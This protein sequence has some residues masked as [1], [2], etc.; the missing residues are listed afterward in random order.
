MALLSTLR[1]RC[2]AV[3]AALAPASVAAA[4][5]V[6]YEQ[7]QQLTTT[8][9]TP[10]DRLPPPG[11]LHP[12]LSAT[13]PWRPLRLP[14]VVPRAAVTPIGANSGVEVAWYRLRHPVSSSPQPLAL[15]TA[16]VLGGPIEV[17]VQGRSLYA[18]RQEWY[19]QWN[20]PVLVPIPVDVQ[21]GATDL[22]IVIGLARR[23]GQSHAMSSLWVGPEAEVR[24]LY[25]RRWWLQITAPQVSSLTILVLGA[26]S[27]AFWLR[28]RHETA[29]LL[30]AL[31]SATWFVRNL[32]YHIDLPLAPFAYAWFWWLSHA[33]LSWV[34]V[35]VYLF[36]FRFHSERYPRVER[37]LVGFTLLISI[38]TL[39]LWPWA[40]DL[41]V[42]QHMLNAAVS[43]GVTA[44]VSVV[45]VR[46]GGPELRVMM[47][48]LWVG[49]AL[50][51]HDLALVAQQITPESI[52]LMPY[53]SLVLFGAFLY[54]VQRRYVGAITQVEQAN[55]EMAHQ[56]L[57][58]QRELE[59]NYQRLALAEKEQARLTERQRLMREMHD[60][61]GST[62]TSSLVLLEQGQLASH[63]VADVLR[64]CVDDLRLTLDSLEP[65]DHDLLALLALLRRRLGRRLEQTG[66]AFDWQVRDLPPLPWLDATAGLHLLRI[67]QESLVNAL[68]HARAETVRVETALVETDA[69]AARV[70]VRITDDGFGFD[71]TA[72]QQA[73]LGGHGWKNMHW[74]AA[75]LG[76][77]IEIESRRGRTAVSLW[78]PVAVPEA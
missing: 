5:P 46:R 54:A 12:D 63:A 31:A 69:G 56:L 59:S 33:S 64:E 45:A 72:A 30:F 42:L 40:I 24:A 68:K 47:V 27:L 57:L 35:L 32:H 38:G 48:A 10:T 67:L 75:K 23:P 3:L 29:Y 6:H 51:L 66:L 9:A 19:S 71:V 74:R 11:S 17:Q 70:L 20:R 73:G 43:I 49:I 34:M 36:A 15:Y 41:L 14:E 37:G 62:L 39:P 53:A 55:A 21:D 13:A 2:I 52:Y 1:C 44:F 16:R 76:G 50:G 22:D 78:L 58:Q 60:G 61:L 18:S 26:F 8:L 4:G 77:R 28:R 7:V 25:E 65:I